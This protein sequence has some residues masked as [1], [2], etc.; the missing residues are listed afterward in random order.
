MIFLSVPNWI[1]ENATVFLYL[2]IALFL[3]TAITVTIAV[4]SAKKMRAQNKA[5]DAAV[6]VDEADDIEVS[7]DEFEYEV[8]A[9]TSLVLSVKFDRVKNSWIVARSDTGRVV[10]RVKTKQE[11]VSLGRKLAVQYN[12]S[13]R[14]HKK[15]GKFQKI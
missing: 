6:E 14:V 15:D 7:D 13:L 12:A 10:R 4:I 11:A 2:S 1:T 8:K 3:V 9:Q 5:E